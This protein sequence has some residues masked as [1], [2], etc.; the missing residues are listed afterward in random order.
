MLKAI[1]KIKK[2]NESLIFKALKQKKSNMT[3][4]FRLFFMSRSKG[5]DK[6]I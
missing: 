5:T 4:K 3:K 6:Q 1:L 2:K